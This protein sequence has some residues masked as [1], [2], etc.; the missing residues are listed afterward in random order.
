MLQNLSIAI[1]ADENYLDGLVGTLVGAAHSTTASVIDTKVLDCGIS[2]S[3]WALVEEFFSKAYPNLK[4]SRHQI[5]PEKLSAFNPTGKSRHLNTSIY[6]RLAVPD[7]FPDLKRIIYLD[8]D[9]Y[10]NADLQLLYVYPLDG[11][12]IGAVHEA[13][14]PQL[15]QNVPPEHLSSADLEL[16]AFN[17]GIL[18]MDL[19]AIRREKLIEQIIKQADSIGDKFQDQGMLNYALRGKWKPLP[20]CWNRQLFVT[21]NFSIYRDHPKSVW[22][23]IGKMKPWH[24]APKHARGLMADFQRD[25]IASGWS[26]HYHGEWRS[27]SPAW[28][29]AL[30]AT[31]AHTLR[32]L[33]RLIT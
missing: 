29:D 3:S 30:K 9:L 21:E 6:A 24:F 28:R 20:A 10:I 27:Q 25:M 22:H 16:P 17:C 26:P 19:A 1:A 33:R 8:A 7:L 32:M 15:S 23:F 5:S 4:L 31:R 13:H 14:L 12:L 18:L 2:D 11:A